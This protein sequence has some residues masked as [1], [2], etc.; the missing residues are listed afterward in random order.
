MALVQ[1]KE[2]SKEY[3]KVPILQGV[4][5]TIEE[6]DVYGIIGESGSGKTTLLN[7]ITGFLQ[8]TDG[9][10]SY[11]I[12]ATL[13]ARDLSRELHK[14]KKQIGFTPQHNSFYPKLTVKENLIHFG[15]LY[16]VPEATL[17]SNIKNLLTFTRLFEHR[18]KIAEHLSEG[19]RRRLDIACSLI[20]KPKVLVLDEPTADLDSNLQKEILSLLQQ[21]NKQGVTIVIASHHLD[22][23]EEICN[24]VA[25]VNKG[26]V[27]CHG[28]IDEVKKPFLRENV[29]ITLKPGENK[30][31]IL[32]L[33]RRLPVEK[34]V[35]KGNS[36][37]V[38][39]NDIQQTVS[40]LLQMIKEQ[41]LY[42]ND[43]DVRKPSLKEIFETITRR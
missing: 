17:V 15:K 40:G 1:L 14:V 28:L 21:A 22:N 26:N 41:N 6:G 32:Q 42:L 9:S 10:I 5:L 23:V 3:E 24:K 11:Q 7:M 30:E 29:T 12:E 38:Y 33:I 19:M 31:Q 8:P 20:H 16:N 34:I 37:V 27:F 35:D 4:N 43:M 39:P 13:P 18:N 25:I 2:V 36:L